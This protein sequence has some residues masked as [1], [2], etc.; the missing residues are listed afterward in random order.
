ME[1]QK[2]E[3]SN[4][5]GLENIPLHQRSLRSGRTAV[6]ARNV[7]FF[8]DSCESL[9]RLGTQWQIPPELETSTHNDYVDLSNYLDHAN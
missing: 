1:G 4:H 9:L 8:C 6:R 5:W 2:H 7:S 3:R